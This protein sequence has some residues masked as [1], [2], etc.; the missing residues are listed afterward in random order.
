MTCK[1]CAGGNEPNRYVPGCPDRTRWEHYFPGKTFYEDS[2][3]R[4]ARS[5]EIEA[6]YR[7]WIAGQMGGGG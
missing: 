5:D 4:C 3:E 1:H 6:A 7:V 2:S